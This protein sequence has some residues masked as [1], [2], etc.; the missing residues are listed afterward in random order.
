MKTLVAAL[1]L[2][3]LAL[4]LRLPHGELAEWKNDEAIQFSH[5]RAIAHDH[6]LP[7]RGL[8]TTDGP[9]L[10]V[11]FLYVLSVP[12]F[13]VDSP[14]AVRV[15]I[16][17][18]ASCTVVSVFLVG[19]RDVGARTAL[20]W[21]FLLAVLPDEVRRGRWSWNP[22]LVPP[23]A[24]LALLLLVRSRKNPRGW[25][26]GALLAFS[27]LLPLIHYSLVG[28]GAIAFAFGLLA[29]ENR[30]A[31]LAG[32]VLALALLAPHIVIESKSGFQATRGAMDVAR[33]NH[34]DPE[35][36]PLAFPRL[37]FQA[38]TLENYARAAG[39]EP[40]A[41]EPLVSWLT[42][43]LLLAGVL[44]GARSL[45]RGTLAPPGIALLM[46]LSAWGPFLLLSLPARH[47]YVQTA[48]PALA[49]L[50]AYALTRVRAGGLLLAPVGW[51]SVLSV[52]TVLHFAAS[53]VIREDS[54]YNLPFF[55]KK[56]ACKEVLERELELV[57]FP[58]SAQSGAR[59]EY[60]VLLEVCYRELSP[61]KQAHFELVRQEASPYWD[62]TV[63]IPHPRNPKGRVGIFVEGSSVKLEE[64]P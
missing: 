59:F 11:H 22:N 6:V 49:Y 45:A 29:R 21:A 2:L 35:R 23:L 13:F 10:P 1:A 16:A 8:P 61:E 18:L 3:V 5:E 44:L 12:L 33:R 51:A 47:H 24:S 40:R 63:E 27:A 4:A 30:R 31:S 32:A 60:P 19:K 52:A 55:E 15:W 28:V 37:A 7:A 26:G 62:L 57:R 20:A 42:R 54:D 39:T 50:A 14:E 48:V 38:F 34:D 56:R 46:A 25:A 9:R 64:I 36:Q 53:H 41:F 17:L 58:F 43:G